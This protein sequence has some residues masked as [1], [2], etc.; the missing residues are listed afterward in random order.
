MIA[1]IL[2]LLLVALP[3]AGKMTAPIL[4]LLLVVPPTAGIA[5]S[6][7]ADGIVTR[8]D[9]AAGKISIRHGPLKKFGMDEGMTMVFR[10]KDPAM[11][12]GLKVGDKVKF[13]VERIN[14]QF[15]ITKIVKA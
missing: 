15:T 8:I 5:Q 11:L 2:A 3:T 9:Q 7:T 4:A 13:D 10:L 12:K 1:P 14:G 6:E